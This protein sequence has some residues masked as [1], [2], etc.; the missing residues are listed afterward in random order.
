MTADRRRLTTDYTAALILPE[1][2]EAAAVSGLPSVVVF[3]SI[4]HDKRVTN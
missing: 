1:K 4:Q 3:R 2:G